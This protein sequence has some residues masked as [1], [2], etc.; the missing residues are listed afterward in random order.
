M[1]YTNS[2]MVVYTKLSPN[3]SGL[4]T[5]GI[6]RITPHCVVGQWTA[7]YLGDWFMNIER[8]AS[9]NYGIDR[10]GR[11][12]LYVEEKNRSWCSSS[13]ANDQRAVTIECAS[14]TEAPYAFRDVVYQTLIRLCTDICRRSGKKKLLWLEDRE[15]TLRY[16]PAPDEMLLTVH[17]WY[18]DKPCPGD[19]MFARMGDLASKVTARLADSA[20]APE[21]T[22][23][24][25]SMDLRGLMRRTAR[26][27]SAAFAIEHLPETPCF[28]NRFEML[29]HIF[30]SE[31][32]N[33]TGLLLEF[34]VYT[35]SSINLISEHRP[36]RPVYGFVSFE[37]LPENRT[38]DRRGMY[39]PGGELPAVR[40]NVQL[41]KGRFDETLPPFI[42]EHP[43]SVFLD[44]NRAG[45][46]V[47]QDR[48][49]NGHRLRCILQLSRV[50]AARIP[51]VYGVH[52]AAPGPVS[53]HRLLQKRSARRGKDSRVTGYRL[54]PRVRPA[55]KGS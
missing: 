46:A 17:R 13:Q 33:D 15:R 2:P 50:A 35:G 19:W 11:V 21:K 40:S 36:M 20:D 48:P 5:L 38:V 32:L 26:L 45:P 37:G 39:T 25:M 29:Q 12:A 28:N 52:G 14:D 44:E 1:A 4:R 41:I 34:G 18:D 23:G 30:C 9:S 43:E 8:Q 24:E 27:Q 55:R 3:H 10:D 6:D 51:R 53:V 49:R 22:A 7:E 31:G 16:S 54:K 42:G 47:R